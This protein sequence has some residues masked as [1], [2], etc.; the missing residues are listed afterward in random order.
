MHFENKNIFPTLVFNNY[1]SKDG[2]PD[3][4]FNSGAFHKGKSGTFYFGTIKGLV[5]FKPDKIQPDSSIAKPIITELLVNDQRWD[6][7]TAPAYLQ[8]LRL[9]PSQNNLFVQF[10]SIEMLNAPLVQYAYKLEGW[11]ENWIYSKIINQ[12]RYNN[13]LPGSYTLKIK[14][15]NGSGIWSEPTTIHIYIKPPFRKTWWFYTLVG[16]SILALVFFVN[17]WLLQQKLKDQLRELEKQKAIEKER[18]RISKDMHDEMGSG[19]TRISLMSE[20]ILTQQKAEEEIK[21]DVGNISSTARKLVETMS[22]IVWALNPKNDT[23]ENLLA[24][25]REQ[26]LNYFEPFGNIRY[27]ICFPDSVPDI[28]LTNEQRRNLYLVIKEAMN[29]ALKHSAA[30]EIHLQMNFTNNKICFSITDNGCSFDVQKIKIASNGLINM[31][32]RMEEIG[33]SFALH[34]K[35][36]QT[37]IDICLLVS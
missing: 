36:G 2:L 28:K 3:D 12:A 4:E 13:L 19:L 27:K 26:T 21:K 16:V 29:N 35:P 22:E 6:S 8:T 1:T 20:L 25:V 33:A 30:T 11:D 7:S 37:Q 9:S 15:A 18:N 34:T 5:W 31:K 24:Y 14:A 23:L 10:R 32:K 17:K